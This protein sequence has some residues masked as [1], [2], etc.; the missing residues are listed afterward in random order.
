MPNLG[1]ISM[2]RASGAGS[3]KQCERLELSASLPVQQGKPSPV[4]SLAAAYTP[5]DPP[6]HAEYVK[7]RIS[8]ERLPPGFTRITGRK[9]ILRP[10]AIESVFYMYR[11][12]GDKHW[13]E[14]GWNMFKAVQDHTRVAY[15]NSAI[16]D[17]TKH[18][19]EMKDEEESFW[20]AETVKYFFLLFSEPGVVSLD[21]Y[22][23]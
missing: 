17:V 23:L 18:A 5:S 9:Y 8:E 22:V 7:A 1:V 13:R 16:D 19:P 12:T 20:L 4:S 15:G 2:I 21:E 3:P 10:E 6:S 11:I 14:V